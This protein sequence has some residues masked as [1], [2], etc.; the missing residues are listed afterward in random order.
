[1]FGYLLPPDQPI[2]L[3]NVEVAI[4][5]A[6]ITLS[7]ACNR[8]YGDARSRA[9][10]ATATTTNGRANNTEISPAV[11]VPLR[12]LIFHTSTTSTSTAHV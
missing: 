10:S 4:Y 1:V 7:V 2:D 9:I 5:K 6:L 8:G 12:D 11:M 3:S